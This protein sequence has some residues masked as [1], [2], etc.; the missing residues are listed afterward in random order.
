LRQ[1]AVFG[2]VGVMATVTYY[3]AALGSHEGLGFN[4]YAA[5]FI[6]YVCAGVMSYFGHGLLTF[7]VALNHGMLRRF[8]VVTITTFFISEAILIGLEMILSLPHR[9]SLA[10]IVVTIP[11]ISFLLHKLWVYRY[12]NNERRMLERISKCRERR[13]D[14]PGAPHSGQKYPRKRSLHASK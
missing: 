2:V 9:M 6:G 10:V 7:R 14:I 1:L 11:M 3:L 13:L 8:I 5:N 12:P 4:L